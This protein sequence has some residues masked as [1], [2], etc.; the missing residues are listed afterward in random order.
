[1]VIRTPDGSEPILVEVPA[2][3]EHQLQELMK[4][5]PDLLPLDDFEVTGPLVVIGREATVASGAVDL[6]CVARSG[7][8]LI[9]E[10]KTG[11][12]N[13]DF[14]H[15]VAQ[16]I[17]YGS[18]IWGLDFGEFENSIALRFFN[19][20]RCK[21]PRLK[22]KSSLR[23]AAELLW[24]GLSPEEWS[25]IRGK[26]ESQLRTGGF[27]YLLVAQRF[28][29]TIERALEYVNTVAPS[30]RFFAVEMVKFAGEGLEVYES[31]TFL[32]PP[33]N[34][35]RNAGLI[36][37]AELLNQIENDAYRNKV[38][39]LLEACR[40]FGFRFEWGAV[41]GSIRL[42]TP[43]RAE[44][45]TVAWV[46][47]PGKPGWMGLTDLSM[48]FDSW[49][50]GNAKGSGTILKDYAERA[51]KLPGAQPVRAK[52]LVAYHFTPDAVIASSN[53]ITEILG[54]LSAKVS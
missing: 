38:Q 50:A 17:D 11:P 1:M 31:R 30:C 3:S 18:H 10:F 2:D 54:D 34:S 25:G 43:F 42:P 5:K 45:V 9:I 44:P 39:E 53:A 6:A 4:D 7:E 41:G 48:G 36:S 21:D 37:E 51:S 28:T 14:R 12:Q 52:N 13:T 32:K 20:S 49:S 8:I 47:P 26:I 40:G 46:F 24:E 27:H 33:A 29:P 19:D 15:A 23:D 35:Q 16:L 22:G